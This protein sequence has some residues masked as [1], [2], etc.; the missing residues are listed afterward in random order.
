MSRHPLDEYHRKRD[1]GATPE[2]AGA[3]TAEAPPDAGA[4]P[5]TFVVH[6]HAAR[7]LHYDLRLEVGGVYA[8]WAVPKGPSLDTHDRH[9]AV[10]VEDHPLEYGSF[11]GTIPEGEYGAGTVMIWDRGTFEPVGDPAAGI[12]KGDFKFVLSGTKLR[13][14]WVL[15]RMKPRPKEKRESWLLIKERDDFARSRDEYDILTAEPDSAATGL[16]M[17][18]IAAGD[19]PAAGAG[20]APD[21][22]FPLDAP[23]Q[24]AALA[25]EAP[26]GD[27]WVHEV[28]FDGYRL[29][30]A[31]EGGSARALTRNGEDWSERFP[32][33][34]KAARA[35]PATSALLD[36]EAVVFDADGR[37]DFGRLQEALSAED[38]GAVR[39]EAFDLLYLN[40][41]DLRAETLLR[42]AALL[43][44]LLED[45]PEGAPLHAVE[46]FAGRGPDYH[47]ASCRLLLEGSVSKRGDRPW[48]PGRSRDWLKVK[49]LARQELVV[50][51]WTD[52]AGSRRGFG[53]LLLGV[54]DGSGRLR[55]AGRVGTGF[56]DRALADLEAR[57]AAIVTDAPPFADLPRATH[58]HWV[59]PELV[60]EVAFREWTHDGLLRQASFKGLREDKAPTEVAREEA[61]APPD[62]RPRT[63]PAT[64]RGIALTNPDRALEPAGI[65]KLELARYYDAVADRMLPH[66]LDRPLTIVRCPHGVAGEPGCFFQKHP[67]TRGWPDALGTVEIEDREGPAVYFF[68][69]D[70]AGLVALAQLGTLEVHTW[71]SL[72]G[73]PERPDRI[74][75]D[76]DPGLGVEFAQ[77]AEGARTVRDA[78][79]ALGLVAFVKTTGGHGLH[80]VVPIVAERGYEEVRAFAHGVVEVLARERPGGFTALAS[81]DERP[82]R[83]FVDYLRNAHG[84]T[85]VCAYSTRARPGAHVSV[86]VTWEEL[87]RGLD[88]ADFD[89]RSVPARLAALTADPWAGYEAARRPLDDAALAAVGTPKPAP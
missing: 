37:S 40:G 73:D 80:V 46:T 47:S 18:Q 10:H 78:L 60:A 35:L 8:S 65:T 49:C 68:V 87:E 39:F 32:T 14:Q 58:A 63:A 79:A 75:F 51:G 82:G 12:A 13:G 5:L 1:F 61:A 20:D 81:K 43:H 36:G 26:D 17:E 11:E 44:A 76:L 7:S 57:L 27:E 56:T 16:T 28:K 86:P 25:D 31:L 55:Y 72:A 2:P 84:A 42:R 53:A 45:L 22:P 50:G 52:P 33:L 64:V 6:E 59:R 70:A 30:L 9:L 29:R 24:L 83:V 23:F 38:S 21:A 69:K 48:V 41:H 67:E 85:A 66:A 71:N 89:I 88:P 34:V 19:E 4:A 15:V 77:V 3:P 62:P 74:V 54:P